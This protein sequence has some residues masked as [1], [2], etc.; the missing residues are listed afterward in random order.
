MKLITHLL[1]ALLGAVL[2]LVGIVAWDAAE[3]A[4]RQQSYRVP[5]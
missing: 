1:A 4:R 3:E 5:R 2:G